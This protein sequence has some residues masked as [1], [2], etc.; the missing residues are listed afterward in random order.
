MPDYKISEL[1]NSSILQP[2]DLTVVARSGTS[3]KKLELSALWEAC[4]DGSLNTNNTAVFDQSVNVIGNTILG[5]SSLNSTSVNGDLS[6]KNNLVVGENLSVNGNLIING[7]NFKTLTGVLDTKIQTLDTKTNSLSSSIQTFIMG[8]PPGS[9]VNIGGGT[10]TIILGGGTNTTIVSGNLTTTGNA[11]ISGSLSVGNVIYTPNG[12]SNQWT[13]TYTTVQNNSGNWNSA[14]TNVVANSGNWNSA[15]TNVV[16]NSGNWNSVFNSYTALSSNFTNTSTGVNTVSS[17]L[18]NVTTIINSLSSNWQNTF[19]TVQ[20]NSGNWDYQGTDLKALSS[21]WQNTF[22]TV[23][24]N[25]GNWDLGAEENFIIACSDET[26]NLNAILS[27]VSFRMPYQLNLLEV[28]ASV[29]TAPISQP[30]ILDINC[31]GVSIFSSRL[32]IDA[33]E[34]TSKTSSSPYLI[35][36]PLLPDDSVIT[37]DADQVGGISSPGNGLKVTFK[38]RRIA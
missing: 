8:G 15:Y 20:N 2:T 30:I 7:T 22:T 29:N 9:T 18:Q 24:N 26:T 37:I 36:N 17:N 28:K 14:Y 1:N 12:N 10:N 27:I 5:N 38:G 6:A 11:S 19:T 33:T 13:S 32:V 23:Q 25:S 34:T 21:N 16:A 35:I 4:L 3:T 31:N